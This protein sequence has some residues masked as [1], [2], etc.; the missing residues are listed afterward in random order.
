MRAVFG[1]LRFFLLG[2]MLGGVLFAAGFAVFASAI[3][4][5]TGAPRAAQAIVALTGGKA[6]I[7]QAVKLLA[8]GKAK[9]LLISG[10]HPS[11]RASQLQRLVPGGADFFPCCV[12]L[13][14]A[15]VDTR[16]NAAETSAWVNRH[17]FTS[18]IVVTSAYHMPRTLIEF[19]WAMPGVQL[20]S[21][22]VISPDFHIETWW[23]HHAT[24]RLLFVEYVKY[25]NTLT[26]YAGARMAAAA[27]FG[28]TARSTAS[29]N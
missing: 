26:Q 9:R 5:G 3:Q 10:V 13:G 8:Q 12:D 2:V 28:G 17:G 24:R 14:R 27:G 20:I 16:G 18:L 4:Q 11:T 19:A 6:R 15:A 7:G 29:A 1:A 21:H 22:P 23:S 25:L